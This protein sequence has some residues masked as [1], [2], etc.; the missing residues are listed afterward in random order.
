MHG[1]VVGEVVGARRP[2]EGGDHAVRDIVDMDAAEH[3][4]WQVDAVRRSRAD[5]VEH[6]AAGAVDAGEAEVVESAAEGA[7]GCG[8]GV[9]VGA[10]AF[11]RQPGGATGREG[12]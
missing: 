12:E 11:D 7:P 3:L 9:A 10:A 6:R 5:A 4:S 1:F 8:G 2:R